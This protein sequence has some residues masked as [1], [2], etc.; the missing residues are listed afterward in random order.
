[1]RGAAAEEFHAALLGR[2][3]ACAWRPPLLLERLSAACVS[4]TSERGAGRPGRPA[5]GRVS[6]V[7]P[8]VRIRHGTRTADVDEQLGPLLLACWRVGIETLMS[9]QHYDPDD[10]GPSYGT[11]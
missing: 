5:G 1:M 11:G 10:G 6:T 3:E 9:C 8:Q 2:Q 7:H 4:P